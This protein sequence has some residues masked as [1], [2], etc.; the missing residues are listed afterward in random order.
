[1]EKKEI[2]LSESDIIIDIVLKLKKKRIK[3]K[4]LRRKKS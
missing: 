3:C 4:F 2:V 1:M